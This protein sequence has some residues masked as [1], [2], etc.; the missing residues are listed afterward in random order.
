MVNPLRLLTA[1]AVLALGACTAVPVA[2]AAPQ[3]FPGAQGFGAA[4][5]GGRGGTVYWVTNLNDSG[6][7]SLRACVQASGPRTCVFRVGGTITLSTVLEVRNPRLTIAGQTAPG[8]GIQLRLSPNHTKPLLRIVTSDVVVRHLR[9]RR[10]ATYLAAAPSGTCCGDSVAA[11]AG[12]DR[13]I[14]D[15]VSV[16]F[17]TDENVDL[18]QARN[19]TIQDSIIAYGLRYATDA[20]TVANPGQHHSM[21]VIIGDGANNISLI[22]NLL[23]FNLN[24]NPR[25]QSGLNE[26]CGNIVYGAQANPIT[27]SGARVNVIG[28]RF[29]PQPSN[30][31]KYVVATNG[32]GTAYAASNSTPVAI[33]SSS[34]SKAATP[35][36]TPVCAGAAPV[37]LATVGA[38]PRDSLDTVTVQHVLDATGALI[39]SPAE[40][41]GWPVL[42]GGTPYAD[43]D[44]DGMSDA[45]ELSRSFDPR[46]A[47][48]GNADPDGNGYT[49]LE[50]FLSEL[51]GNLGSPT[52]VV[53][54]ASAD[55]SAGSGSP[56]SGVTPARR[57][58]RTR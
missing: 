30:S 13:L 45:W 7:G 18:Y 57:R 3:A 54:Q 41:G 47:A 38:M 42:A 22:D 20:D 39:D 26:V 32:G 46:N 56:D 27:I 11:L 48:D 8:G 24:R 37:E 14:L 55:Q 15:H 21:G 58:D 31:Y 5:A 35:F 23:A 4:A 25:I 51:A 6:T 40:I 36:N 53:Q 28:N 50:E 52:A 49:A 12:T 29:D 2:Q 9:L 17:A 44:R 16:G 43:S 34:A 10:G 1:V 19:V 33:F